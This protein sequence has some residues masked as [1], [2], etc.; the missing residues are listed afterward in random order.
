MCMFISQNYFIFIRPTHTCRCIWLKCG[1]H[2]MLYYI[3]LIVW[4]IATIVRLHTLLG[5][6]LTSENIII[7]STCNQYVVFMALDTI[8]KPFISYTK[9]EI[10]FRIIFSSTSSKYAKIAINVSKI[11]FVKS[12]FGLW[13]FNRLEIIG[14]IIICIW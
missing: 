13:K 6:L 11:I 1:R 7:D 12:S 4:N 5:L 2:D 3:T 10:Y 8:F 9:S 14:N